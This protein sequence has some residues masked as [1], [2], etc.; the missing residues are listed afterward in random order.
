MPVYFLAGAGKTVLWYINP[1]MFVLW[2]YNACQF[3]N[4]QGD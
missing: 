2:T 1:S 3:Y 4:Y